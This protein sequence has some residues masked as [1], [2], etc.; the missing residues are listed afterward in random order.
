M[1]RQ[2]TDTQKHNAPL[3]CFRA[4]FENDPERALTLLQQLVADPFSNELRCSLPNLAARRTDVDD[5]FGYSKSEWESLI[6]CITTLGVREAYRRELVTLD[7]LDALTFNMAALRAVNRRIMGLPDVSAEGPVAK[8]LGDPVAIKEAPSV[9]PEQQFVPSPSPSSGLPWWLLAVAAVCLLGASLVLVDFGDPQVD[10][11]VVAAINAE[12]LV[13]RSGQESWKLTA[14]SQSGGFATVL[15]I[16]DNYPLGWENVNQ[17]V[18]DRAAD[19][20]DPAEFGD[21]RYT[22]IVTPSTIDEGQL[23]ELLRQAAQATDDADWKDKVCR[24][25]WNMGHKTM[26]FSIVLARPKVVVE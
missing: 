6:A 23:S 16:T 12:L 19:V 9:V 5:G 4:E 1:G 18:G 8:T 3:L 7:Q 20:L 14:K 26:E 24:G 10:G 15:K 2:M 25:L 22:V 13:K 21:H 11:P 17:K